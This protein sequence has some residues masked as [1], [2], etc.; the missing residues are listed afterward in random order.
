MTDRPHAP[1]GIDDEGRAT[2]SPADALKLVTTTANQRRQNT[3]PGRLCAVSAR[4]RR[5][6]T[7]HRRGHPSAAQIQGAV[8]A[9]EHLLGLGYTPLFNTPTLQALWTAG[10]WRL[11]KRLAALTSREAL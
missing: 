6:P 11:V 1:P 7:P 10:H 3:A 4:Q 5:R 8:A 2:A 9:A